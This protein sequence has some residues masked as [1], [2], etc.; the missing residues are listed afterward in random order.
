MFYTLLFP[1][2]T[3]TVIQ[4]VHARLIHKFQLHAA[5]AAVL[6]VQYTHASVQTV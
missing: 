1:N 3:T 2:F 4:A 6:L 5:V